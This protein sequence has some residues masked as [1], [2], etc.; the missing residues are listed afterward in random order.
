M[1]LYG[2]LVYSQAN[3]HISFSGTSIYQGALLD[4]CLA[5]EEYKMDIK[6]DSNQ[7]IINL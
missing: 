6:W 2:S 4:S 3:Y 1:L 7:Y 5:A